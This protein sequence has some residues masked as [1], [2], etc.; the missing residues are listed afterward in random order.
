MI[1]AVIGSTRNSN[2]T[3]LR[4][5]DHQRMNANYAF[6]IAAGQQRWRWDLNPRRGYLPTRFRGLRTAPSSPPIHCATGPGSPAPGPATSSR[7]HPGRT[8]GRDLRR[9]D[10]RRTSGH[11]AIR[12]AARSPDPCRRLAN[13]VQ[14][15]YFYGV[16]I[17][18]VA[19]VTCTV[20]ANGGTGG[21]ASVIR[22]YQ[23]GQGRKEARDAVIYCPSRW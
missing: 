8:L 19:R 16:T 21:P 9:K 18:F 6:S 7:A 20:C 2:K 4:P 15:P 12:H 11:R 5:G 22:Q 17:G 14:H 3:K 10:P 13:R 23:A 1:A